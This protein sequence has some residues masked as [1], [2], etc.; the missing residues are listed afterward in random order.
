MNIH[1]RQLMRLGRCYIF[2]KNVWNNIH[3]IVRV[4]HMYLE[5]GWAGV[6][7]SVKFYIEIILILFPYIFHLALFLYTDIC[8]WILKLIFTETFQLRG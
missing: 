4:F 1:L 3:I 5:S 6:A 7:I 2:D 8:L